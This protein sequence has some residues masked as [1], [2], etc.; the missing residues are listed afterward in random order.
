MTV[1]EKVYTLAFIKRGDEVLLGQKTRDLGRGL[2]NGFGGKVEP[3]EAILEAAKREIKEECNLEVSDLKHIGFIMFKEVI[4]GV[5]VHTVH[6]VHMFTGTQIKGNP[7]ASEE[8]NPVRWYHRKDLKSL[9]MYEDF[10]YW[11][12]YVFEQDEYFCGW[13]RYQTY[14]E[15]RVILDKFT[16]KCGSLDEASAYLET[17][18]S[19]D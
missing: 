7:E 4:D 1:I 15:K 17:F 11:K 10:R 8:M 14:N 6:I 2:W 16:K 18:K 19:V 13:V 5:N 9:Q 3:G 12:K